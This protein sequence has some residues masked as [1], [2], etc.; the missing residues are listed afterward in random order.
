MHGYDDAAGDDAL[1]ERD[2]LFRDEAEDDARIGLGRRA[3][4]VADGRRNL[5][6]LAAAHR[7]GEERILGV[8]VAQQG[9]GSH[10]KLA[11]DVGQRG[12]GE[13][14]GGED[15]AG[16]VEDLVAADARRTSHL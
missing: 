7:L 3:H 12:G 16:G 4:Q 2:E 15:S 14:F 8:G 1:G 11:G 6:G 13:A 9:G 10:A 5:D